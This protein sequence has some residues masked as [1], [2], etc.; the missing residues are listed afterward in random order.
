MLPQG[1]NGQVGL[2]TA[3]I[4][5]VV[6]SNWLDKLRLGEMFGGHLMMGGN[7]ATEDGTEVACPQYTFPLYIMPQYKVRYQTE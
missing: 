5:R 6:A 2:A 1:Y 7:P 3:G 4:P